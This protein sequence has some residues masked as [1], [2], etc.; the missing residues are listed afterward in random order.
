MT[1]LNDLAESLIRAQ[2]SGRPIAPIRSQLSDGDS[3]AAYRIQ[4]INVEK[5]VAAGRRIIGRKIGLTNPS[6]Q[7]QLGVDRPDFGTLFADMCYGDNG[8]LDHAR[9]IQPKIEAEIAFQLGRDLPH[10]DTTHSDVFE[11][12]RW[13]IPALEVVDSR[14]EHWNIRFT[15]TVADN[16]SCGCF[17]LG[18]PVRQLGNLDLLDCRMSLTRNGETVSTGSGSECLGHPLNAVVW[19][20]RVMAK[21]GTPLK[22]GDVVLSGALGPMVPVNR[23]DSFIAEINGVGRVSTHFI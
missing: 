8:H 1:D 12:I 20:A 23:G 15:D 21:A 3:E 5:G 17:V 7:R 19:L 14:I 22:A 16:A 6:V 9:F 18:G 4:Q 11:A 10:A 13:V 2:E